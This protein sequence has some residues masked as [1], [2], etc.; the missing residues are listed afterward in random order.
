MSVASI[1]LNA[2]RAARTHQ[3][4]LTKPQGALG[5]LEDI[6]CW[7]AARQGKIIPD[8]IKPHICVFAADHGVVQEGVSA[9]PSV[10]TAEMVK[11]FIAG[12]AAINVLA[13]LCQASLRIVDV[14]VASDITSLEGVVHAKVRQGSRNIV[15][16]AAMSESEC[17]QA[18]EVGKQHAE[19]AIAEGANLLIAG[20]MG[21]GNTT[22]S[23]ALICELALLPPEIVVGRGTGIDDQAYQ[24]KLAAVRQALRRA[25]DAP[26]TEALRELG[27]LE[28]AA[29]AGY[30]QAAA[31]LGVPVL[32]DGFISTAAALAA[33]SWDARIAGWYIVG[34]IINFG[35]DIAKILI[36][37]IAIAPHRIKGIHHAVSR[38]TQRSKQ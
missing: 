14:G 30:Y 1:D 7:F 5:T 37:R 20:D 32:L 17:Q 10:V 23:A 24:L 27:G 4:Q 13:R 18:I 34:Y 6:A 9:Y 31:K 8:P 15:Q 12:G 16:E 35:S 25:K 36:T 19:Q 38:C 3:N 26:F 33:V 11:N 29:M 28:I 22:P 2:L 21:I